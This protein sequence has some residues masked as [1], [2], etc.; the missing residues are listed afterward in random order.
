MQGCTEDSQNFIFLWLVVLTSC[1]KVNN[2]KGISR[3]LVRPAVHLQGQGSRTSP[4]NFITNWDHVPLQWQLAI[5][6]LITTVPFYHH[7]V[8]LFWDFFQSHGPNLPLCNIWALH[9]SLFESYKPT[10]PAFT[11]SYSTSLICTRMHIYEAL[12]LLLRRTASILVTIQD[13][14]MKLSN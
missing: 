11:V 2:K 6:K 12:I 1:Y 9:K 5:Q 7:L 10:Q 3:S 4:P 13:S 14:Q 8:H